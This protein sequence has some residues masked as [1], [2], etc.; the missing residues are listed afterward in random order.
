MPNKITRRKLLRESVALAGA[1]LAIPALA[2]A[3]EVIRNHLR[4]RARREA[5]GHPCF[6]GHS[7]RRRHRRSQPLSAALALAASGRCL[8][9]DSARMVGDAEEENSGEHAANGFR[10]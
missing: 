5:A 1:G 9:C 4:P 6:Q 7:V 3:S 2:Q 10:C 8:F